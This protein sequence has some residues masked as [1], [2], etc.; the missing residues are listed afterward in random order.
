MDNSNLYCEVIYTHSDE[1][2]PEWV[3]KFTQGMFMKARNEAIKLLN[4]HYEEW[5]E[6]YT[7]EVTG[8]DDMK[9]N[10]YIQGKQNE[11]LEQFNK[12]WMGPVKLF[13]DEYADIA[14]RYKIF[15]KEYNL[16]MSIKLI[17]EK[18]WREYHRGA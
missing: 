17:N 6:A 3:K 15:G 5:N 12:K 10:S 11:I 2:I 7:D 13:S 9:Y 16:H 18:E 1:S 8:E 4:P 14:G